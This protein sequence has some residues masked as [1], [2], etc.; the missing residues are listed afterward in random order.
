MRTHT[1]RN[2]MKNT[3]TTLVATQV[4]KIVLA[5]DNNYTLNDY[6]DALI[7]IESSNDQRAE[8]YEASINDHSYGLGQ[9]LTRTAKDIEKRHPHLPRLGNTKEQIR[10]SLFNPETNRTYTTTLFKEELDFYQDKFLAVAAYNSGHLTPR[11]A[12]VQ[13]Q[14]ND[15][16]QAN[17]DT[18]GIVGPQ[19]KRIVKKFQG[20]HSL[21]V[22]GIIGPKT[23]KMLQE[24][25]TTK[26]SG[27]PNPLGSIPQNKYTPNHVRKFKKAL[28]N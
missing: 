28:E 10:N 26:F 6:I 5:Q 21:Q 23:Y 18:D 19:T 12:R 4:P 14:L 13:K 27:N 2:F 3:L 9:I 15:L 8:R 22:D 24:V 11:N 16:Y 25:W 7:E 17:L 1:R 20:S